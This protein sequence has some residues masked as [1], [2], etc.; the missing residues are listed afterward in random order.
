MFTSI[1]ASNKTVNATY[2]KEIF[3][4]VKWIKNNKIIQ[5]ILSS[6]IH[7]NSSYAMLRCG[8]LVQEI[9]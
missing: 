7:G 9:L 1:S 6:K 3:L 2:I 4:K 8:V 5:Y